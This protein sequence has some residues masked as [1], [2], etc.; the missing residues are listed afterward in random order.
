MWSRGERPEGRGKLKA[1]TVD[2]ERVIF[3]RK[4]WLHKKKEV[5]KDEHWVPWSLIKFLIFSRHFLKN[6][7]V[8]I[9]KMEFFLKFLALYSKESLHVLRFLEPNSKISE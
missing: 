8:K 3:G 2:E 5:T 9:T 7:S 6:S 4:C 1:A